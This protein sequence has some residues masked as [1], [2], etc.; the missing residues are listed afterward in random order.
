MERCGGRN[1]YAVTRS[2][3]FSFCFAYFLRTLPQ[4]VSPVLLPQQ[5]VFLTIT[6]CFVLFTARTAFCILHS[7]FCILHYTFCILTFAFCILQFTF[8]S[9]SLN[10]IP[11][12]VHLRKPGALKPK[13][14]LGEPWEG[15]VNPEVNTAEDVNTN[16][17]KYNPEQGSTTRTGRRSDYLIACSRPVIRIANSN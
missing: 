8:L 7:A 15:D 10:W 2:F 11:L 1:W 12:R 16:T 9:G 6:V 14:A 13:Q 17:S 4:L 5:A 3:S